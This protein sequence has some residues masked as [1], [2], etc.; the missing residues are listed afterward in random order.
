MDKIMTKITRGTMRTLT[1]LGY[2]ALGLVAA[3]L[4]V[5]TLSDFTITS[6][7][8]VETYNEIKE[9]AIEDYMTRDSVEK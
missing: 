9:Q 4:I 2:V 8:D 7:S 3:S 6:R 1:I 5:W